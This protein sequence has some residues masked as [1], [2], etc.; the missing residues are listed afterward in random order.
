MPEVLLPDPA[1][2]LSKM[3]IPGEHLD[4]PFIAALVSIIGDKIFSR[5]T[6]YNSY[7]TLLVRDIIIIFYEE[8]YNVVWLRGGGNIW[9][10]LLNNFNK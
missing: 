6:S 4:H 2:Y 1:T 9:Q 10:K 3:G 7:L 5:P 8:K